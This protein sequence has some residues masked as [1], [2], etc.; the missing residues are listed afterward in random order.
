MELVWK[1]TEKEKIDQL[2]PAIADKVPLDGQTALYICRQDLCEE[3][4]IQ[5]GEMAKAIEKI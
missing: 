1:R 5:W 4:L 2:L 3:P